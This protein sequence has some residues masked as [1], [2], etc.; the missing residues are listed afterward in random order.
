MSVI[1]GVSV[2]YMWMMFVAMSV[3]LWWATSG[4]M[5][6][7]QPGSMLMSLAHVATEGHVNVVC[8][9]AW[10]HLNVH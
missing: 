7:L 2:G 4:S 6:L 9:G 5:V 10:S 8:G 1:Y 3:L